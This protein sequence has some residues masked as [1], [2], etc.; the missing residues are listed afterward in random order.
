MP[1]PFIFSPLHFWSKT[2]EHSVWCGQVSRYT[3]QSPIMKW[4]NMLILQKKF[5]EAERSLSQQRQLVHWYRWVP[6]ILTYWG[7]P[8]LQG[9]SPPEDNSGFFVG[10]TA[11]CPCKKRKRHW[12]SLSAM[13]GQREKAADCKPG[14]GISP[15]IESMGTL[16]LDF[17]T[18]EL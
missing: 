17:Q 14:S 1:L 13:C 4:A 7:K 10:P 15:D 16:I 8:G 5:T 12:R 9:A 18:P 3:R 2:A 11:Q 6:R